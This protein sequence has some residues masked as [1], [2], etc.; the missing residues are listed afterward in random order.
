MYKPFVSEFSQF[1][2]NMFAYENIFENIKKEKG[3]MVSPK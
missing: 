2:N 3:I 1:S